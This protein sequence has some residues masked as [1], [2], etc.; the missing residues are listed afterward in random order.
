MALCVSAF[1]L[2]HD[3]I[4]PDLNLTGDLVPDLNLAGDL[5]PDLNLTGDPSDRPSNS[6]CGTR[7][8]V[9]FKSNTI[10]SILERENAETQG[11]S[12]IPYWE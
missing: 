11:P 1:S 3:H 9:K 4:V 2:F 5:V 8:P 12:E 10:R 6:K 7:S